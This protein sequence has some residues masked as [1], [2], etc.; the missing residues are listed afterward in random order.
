MKN[1]EGCPAAGGAPPKSKFKYQDIKNKRGDLKCSQ[2]VAI[3]EYLGSI[4]PLC[5][6]S[7]KKNVYKRKVS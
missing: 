7:E 2:I 3:V 4:Y 1:T 6:Y 5:T